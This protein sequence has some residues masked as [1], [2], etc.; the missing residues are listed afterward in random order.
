MHLKCV[1]AVRAKTIITSANFT[2]S[3]WLRNIELGMLV[4]FMSR[5]SL[6]YPLI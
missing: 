2:E 5:S 4:Q 3:A 6:A 1:V